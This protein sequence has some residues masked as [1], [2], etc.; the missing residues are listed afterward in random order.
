MEIKHTLSGASRGAGGSIIPIQLWR[1][2]KYIT[3]GGRERGMSHE[4]V[5]S[6]EYS[7]DKPEYIYIHVDEATGDYIEGPFH[8]GK[9]EHKKTELYRIALKKD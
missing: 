3:H 1:T 7:S 6:L 5:I 9:I 2:P 8:E 4:L